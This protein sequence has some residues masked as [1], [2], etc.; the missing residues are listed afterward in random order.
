MG[1]LISNGSSLIR[2]NQ[3]VQ[4]LPINY[5]KHFHTEASGGQNP[6]DF[7]HVY[8]DSNFCGFL[9]SAYVSKCH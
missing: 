1:D 7:T 3:D 6:H 4:I 2:V 9:D 5:L 8:F